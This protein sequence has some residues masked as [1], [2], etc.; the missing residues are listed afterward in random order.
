M[1]WRIKYSSLTSFF[2]M[3]DFDPFKLYQKHYR[4][5]YTGQILRK[6]PVFNSYAYTQKDLEQAIKIIETYGYSLAQPIIPPQISIYGGAI[7]NDTISYTNII[8]DNL[9][10]NLLRYNSHIFDNVYE[11]FKMYLTINNAI[12]RY[13]SSLN[14][15]INFNL[16]DG[17]SLTISQ[18]TPNLVVNPYSSTQLQYNIG[19]AYYQLN[20]GA[21][22]QYNNGL[23][24]EEFY[25]RS[26]YEA[27]LNSD[28]SDIPEVVLGS[29]T[30]T[31][32]HTTVWNYTVIIIL[33]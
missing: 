8:N 32:T 27:L 6:K 2:I 4:K 7:N 18:T 28:Y 21:A 11:N 33:N 1:Q 24:Y 16:V 12:L 25:D 23:I 19:N 17:T 30:S 29:L 14:Y 20:R 13:S 10:N 9:K 31:Y 15:P 3:S 5:S 22:E 26:I